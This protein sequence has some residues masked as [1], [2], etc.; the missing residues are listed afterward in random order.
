MEIKLIKKTKK[1]E[2]KSY[3]NFYLVFPNGNSIA[4]KPSFKN[5]YVI[6]KMLAQKLEN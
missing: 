3:I 1:I 4:I 2:N 5:D 6:L